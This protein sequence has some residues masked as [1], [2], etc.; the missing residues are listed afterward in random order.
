MSV[1]AHS[2]PFEFSFFVLFI[3]ARKAKVKQAFTFITCY[4]RIKSKEHLMKRKII[5]KVC[6][7]YCKKFKPFC[8]RKNISSK[9]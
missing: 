9:E 6:Y 2:R 1:A 8:L 7:K 3:P 5:L 4:G